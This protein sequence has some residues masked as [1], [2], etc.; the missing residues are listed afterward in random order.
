M[1]VAVFLK[2]HI[3]N[4]E[5]SAFQALLFLKDF[6][7]F[8]DKEARKIAT[9]YLEDSLEYCKNSGNQTKDLLLEFATKSKRT[10]FKLIGRVNTSGLELMEWCDD[11]QNFDGMCS[12]IEDI[13]QAKNGDYI[14]RTYSL[15]ELPQVIENA[16]RWYNSVKKNHHK[17]NSTMLHILAVDDVI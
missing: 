10:K 16:L 14:K 7:K 5:H 11:I 9:R 2:L 13:K 1:L 3:M 4:I 12:S 15:E 8:D 17:F 6:D